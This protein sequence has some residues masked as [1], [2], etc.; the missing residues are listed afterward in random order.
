MEKLSIDEKKS[1]YHMLSVLLG[2][3]GMYFFVT[4]GID[5]CGSFDNTE[6]IMADAFDALTFL[7]LTLMI[8]IG[9]F[10]WLWTTVGI[11]V[12]AAFII[13]TQIP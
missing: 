2:C 12:L 13:S 6:C 5:R 9:W 4:A 11:L 3:V 10:G 7:S 8:V 1:V